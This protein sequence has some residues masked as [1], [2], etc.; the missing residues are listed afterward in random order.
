MSLRDYILS[1]SITLCFQGAATVLL[2][3]F[4]LAAG[5]GIKLVSVTFIF[6]VIII[7]GWLLCGYAFEVCRIKRLERLLEQVQDK[8]L[9]GELL[10]VPLG[11]VEKR[12]YEIMKSISRS[13]ISEVENA[14]REKEKYQDYLEKWVHEIKTPLTACSLILDNGGDAAKLRRELKKVD[15][16]TESIL[17]Y[18]RMRDVEKDTQIKE[19]SVYHVMNQAV[20]SQMEILIGAGISVEISGDFNIY[21]D[22]KSLNFILKQILINCG[23]YCPKCKVRLK[24]DGERGII[25][26]E[27][28]GIGIP[29]YEINR[30]FERGFSGTNGRLTGTST[31]MGLYIVKE[32]C[33][34]LDIDINIDSRLGEYTCIKLKFNSFCR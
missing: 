2:L 18:G 9:A 30:V 1:K 15:N 11:A 7:G 16:L 34:Q 23:K 27:D 8:Y 29:S 25:S 32:L 21:T 26:I 6:V 19:I 14:V 13:A 28:N 17:Y 10:P 4:M 22:E 33:R 3:S 12:Y 5:I 20:K 24:A 31:G